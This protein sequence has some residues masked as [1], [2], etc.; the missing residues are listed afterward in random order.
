MTGEGGEAEAGGGAARGVGETVVE[1]CAE[2]EEAVWGGCGDRG[3]R[4]GRGR[5]EVVEAADAEEGAV[6]AVEV[7]GTVGARVVGEEG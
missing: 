4:W 6:G 1:F 5:V 7:F 2:R 3:G